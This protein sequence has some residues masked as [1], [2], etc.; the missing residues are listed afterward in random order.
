MD[1]KILEDIGL[2]KSEIKVYVALLKLGKSS[3]GQI[4]EKAGIQNSVLHFSLNKLIDKGIISYIMNGKIK[5]YT[6]TNPRNLIDYLKN[7]EIQ[8]NS[9]LPELEEVQDNDAEDEK[10]EIFE[11]LGGMTAAMNLLFEDAKRGDEYL[12]TGIDLEERNEELQEFYSRF[13]IKRKAKGISTRGVVPDTMRGQLSQRVSIQVRY[14]S[15]PVPANSG[16]CNN[17]MVLLSWGKKPKAVY[18]KSQEIVKRQKD[19]FE[20]IWKLAKK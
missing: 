6:A 20:L 19:L 7:K 5:I 14:A 12:F 11:G 16:M 18:I 13:D 2:T 8:L 17:K 3:A 1:T 10:V 4:L 15:F 9:L